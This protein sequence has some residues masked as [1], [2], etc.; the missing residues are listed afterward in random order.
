MQ[1]LPSLLFGTSASLDALLVSISCGLRRVHIQILQNLII[2]LVSL[3]GT[4]LSVC[5]GIRLLSFLPVSFSG[6]IGSI[7]LILLGLY[8]VIKRFFIHHTDQSDVKRTGVD[9]DTA[10]TAAMEAS[11][12]TAASM[13]TSDVNTA[14]MEAASTNT[15]RTNVS[16][17]PD[18]GR[19]L[20]A[21]ETFILSLTLSVNNIGIGLS[22][23]MAGLAPL[24]A[25]AMTFACSVLFLLCGNHLGRSRFLHLIGNWADPISGL[26]LIGL[27][28]IQLTL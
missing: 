20:S 26:L 9:T 28:A 7:I 5:L 22:A 21:W 2:S 15:T 6:C 12:T 14:A 18:G 16:N 25:A 17:F 24:P 3:L 10:E 1:L 23:S 4:C 19:N 8:Y 27:G 13:G 11:D